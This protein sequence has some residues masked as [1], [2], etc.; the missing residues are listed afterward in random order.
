MA[1][2]KKSLLSSRV[3]FRSQVS[4][5]VVRFL[6]IE[7]IRS[8]AIRDAVIGLINALNGYREE[9]LALF[10]EVYVFQALK[11]V[12]DV[13]KGGE[14]VPVGANPNCE[15]AAGLALKKC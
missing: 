3:S 15:V 7:R 9:G 12:Q 13:L 11:D 6:R 5:E 2:V 14:F 1:S 8:A 10:P 4:L